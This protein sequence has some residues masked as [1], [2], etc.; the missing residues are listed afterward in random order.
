MKPLTITNSNF[1]SEVMQS[2][3]PV[4]LDFW[5]PMCG[6]CLRISPILDEIAEEVE[7]VKVGKINVMDNPE[8]AATFGVQSIPLLV[9]VKDGNIANQA[10][11]AIPKEALMELI[12]PFRAA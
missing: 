10:L 3:K 8:L 9:V 7:D 2:D 5:S 12:A 11:G 4:L 6:P 1:E